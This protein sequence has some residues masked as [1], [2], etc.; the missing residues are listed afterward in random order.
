MK[1]ILGNMKS[2]CR[3]ADKKLNYLKQ[4]KNENKKIRKRRT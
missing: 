1:K 4:R 3:F 2:R